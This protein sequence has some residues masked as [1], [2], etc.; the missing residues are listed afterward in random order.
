MA[1][2]KWGLGILLVVLAYVGLAYG[3]SVLV[4]LLVRSVIL[5]ALLAIAV[6]VPLLVFRYL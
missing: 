4:D 5:V 3:L 6:L 2:R 1:L